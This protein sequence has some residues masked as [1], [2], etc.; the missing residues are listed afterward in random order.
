[1][2]NNENISPEVNVTVG[3]NASISDFLTGENVSANSAG[4]KLN[5]KLSMKP[6]DTRIF[7]LSK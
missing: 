1:V 6:Y 4:K 5:F 7:K 2:L 3:E